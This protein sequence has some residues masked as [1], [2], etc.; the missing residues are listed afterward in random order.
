MKGRHSVS[1]AGF[2]RG[3]VQPMLQGPPMNGGAPHQY[4]QHL[5]GPPASFTSQFG[6][7]PSPD[8]GFNNGNGWM[9]PAAGL[10]MP[11]PQFDGG[12]AA[13]VPMM[14]SLPFTGALAPSI[15]AIPQTDGTRSLADHRLESPD[16]SR[17][18]SIKAPDGKSG[19]KS[20]LNPMSPAYK[21][22]TAAGKDTSASAIHRRVAT[23]L[24]PMHQLSAPVSN[25]VDSSSATDETAVPNKR[26]DL[27]QSSSVTSFK[28]ADFF[29]GNPKE[30]S[31]RQHVYAQ[32]Y[33]KENEDTEGDTD[34]VTPV[35]DTFKSSA[36]DTGDH[37]APAAPPGTPIYYSA[38]TTHAPQ[39]AK[40]ES[41]NTQQA[42]MDVAD[43][44]AHN[45]SPKN[46][47]DFIFI[48]EDPS[49]QAPSTASSPPE[50][51][52]S[53]PAERSDNLQDKSAKWLH[54]FAA[55]LQKQQPHIEIPGFFT[56]CGE[57]WLAG[58]C[59]GIKATAPLTAAATAV[60]DPPAVN[61]SSLT[62]L[63]NTGT[64]SPMK[65]LSRRPSPAIASRSSS[66]LQ[67]V[68]NASSSTT[69]LPF[70]S[71]TKSIDCLK[72]AIIAPQNE[73][74]ILTPAANGLHVSEAP[75]NLGTWA[76]KPHNHPSM[77]LPGLGD[78]L[79]ECHRVAPREGSPDEKAK[80][81]LDRTSEQMQ[82]ARP[83]LQ[84]NLSTASIASGSVGTGGGVP[85]PSNRVTSIDS[86]MLT[87]WP[88]KHWPANR[89]TTPSEWRSAG[90][91]QSTG[92]NTGFFAHPQFDG[93][94]DTS[95]RSR[96]ATQLT[97]GAPGA[98]QR[99]TSDT[100]AR[101]SSGGRFREGSID[102][103]TSPPTSPRPMS[104]A[105]SPYGTPVRRDSR[106]NSPRKGPSPSKVM[107]NL[108]EKV[109]IKVT[110]P[111]PSEMGDEPASPSGKRGW[112]GVRDWMKSSK[113]S[114]V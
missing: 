69:R 32:S 109:G 30:H 4:G 23:P 105:N 43:R 95:A 54:G 107:G 41:S 74:A 70:E 98:P 6:S 90:V 72:Q 99:V 29:P 17:A 88:A 37:N 9:L 31:A 19:L 75:F 38:P 46:K 28:T 49:Q 91:Q 57:D 33:D 68:E 64:S 73:N 100:H 82:P 22:S 40:A 21:P 114:N 58:Y 10:F 18:V 42:T 53:Q 2:V 71:S 8:E 1:S 112:G 50:D 3:N 101:L 55:G 103:I 97:T 20:G 106:K 81:A 84:S 52:K 56:T 36:P 111:T 51:A 14:Q 15:A 24:S 89:V 44:Q 35:R 34:A 45:I 85:T 60:Q 108:A 63:S 83:A 76:M 61:N 26:H 102:R 7:T 78:P 11:P 13:P 66:R 113:G 16:R 25:T 86:S 59:I 93:T 67:A 104:P 110:S 39:P 65:A 62:A 80:L 12:M 94:D 87:Q 5:N 47:R 79:P 48:N 92:L 96:S 27:V 77:E